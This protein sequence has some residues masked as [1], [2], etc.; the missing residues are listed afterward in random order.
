MVEVNFYE[1][2]ADIVKRGRQY[3]KQQGE[4]CERKPEQLSSSWNRYAFIR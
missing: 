2:V 3:L 1:E 4:N